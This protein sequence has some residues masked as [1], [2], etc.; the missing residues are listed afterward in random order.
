[1][2]DDS[3]NQPTHYFASHAY[4]FQRGRTREE[5]FANLKRATPASVL[6]MALTNHGP[7]KVNSWLVNQELVSDYPVDPSTNTPLGVELV[8]HRVYEVFNTR[9]MYR[10]ITPE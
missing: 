9:W 6:L 10:D 8:G 4:A 7:L 3:G 1:M 2:R 5:A